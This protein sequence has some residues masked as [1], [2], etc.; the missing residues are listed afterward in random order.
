MRL[1]IMLLILFSAC[2]SRS[3]IGDDSDMTPEPILSE[4]SPSDDMIQWVDMVSSALDMSMPMPMN[5]TTSG[6][7]IGWS[8]AHYGPLCRPELI[9]GQGGCTARPCSATND[10]CPSLGLMCS[11]GRCYAGEGQRC[12][13]CSRICSPY[14]GLRCR[15]RTD[16]RAPEPTCYYANAGLPC[17]SEP[18]CPSDQ[19]CEYGKCVV[20]QTPQCTADVH[21]K[22]GEKCVLGVCS[23]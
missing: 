7:C 1:T 12:D 11:N 14:F 16:P 5:M 3:A 13:G 8:C 6:V 17:G 9:C 2:E 4:M 15:P 18:R 22:S 21:C 23:K 19:R 20:H 10:P